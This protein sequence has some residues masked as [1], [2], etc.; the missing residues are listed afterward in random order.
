[1]G[2]ALCTIVRNWFTAPAAKFVDDYFGASLKH[3]RLSGGH[4]LDVVG[5]LLGMPT[6]EDK[7]VSYA[8][9]LHVLGLILCFTPK[10]MLA[11]V[12]VDPA[13]AAKWSCLLRTIVATQQS[14]QCL[15]IMM[16]GR[17][18][19]AVMA[20]TGRVGRAYLRPFFACPVA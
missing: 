7:S 18:S 6:K 8:Q 16:A 10:Q 11:E 15:A 14:S 13:K 19:F 12:T 17:L 3:V 20:S 9:S 4:C 1:M 2:T 5:S